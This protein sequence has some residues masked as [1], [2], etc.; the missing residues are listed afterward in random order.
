[1]K[2]D[3]AIDILVRIREK[4]GNDIEIVSYSI[5]GNKNKVSEIQYTEKYTSKEKGYVTIAASEVEI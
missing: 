2:I 4:Q 5:M 1:M 3:R